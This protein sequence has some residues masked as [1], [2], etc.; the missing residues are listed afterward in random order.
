[1]EQ[2]MQVAG[3]S[4]AAP[5]RAAKNATQQHILPSLLAAS[6]GNAKAA[7]PI[8][9]AGSGSKTVSTPVAPS[10]PDPS[11]PNAPKKKMKKKRRHGEL[12][13]TCE[14]C[15][16]GLGD[17][18]AVLPCHKCLTQVICTNCMDDDMDSFVCLSCSGE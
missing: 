12:L 2:T 5:A 8:K 10:Q 9:V 11:V 7:S 17:D 1:M 3:A 15:N 13:A 6:G 18:D 16:I 14:K 4:G